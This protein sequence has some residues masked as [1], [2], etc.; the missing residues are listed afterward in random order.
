MYINFTFFKLLCFVSFFLIKPFSKKRFFFISDENAFIDIIGIVRIRFLNLS[1]LRRYFNEKTPPA[2]R[3]F[4]LQKTKFSNVVGANCIL[5][6]V[7]TLPA[8]LKSLSL[9]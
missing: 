1:T 2:K 4:F 9:G 5:F 6:M 3:Q 7:I 8:S